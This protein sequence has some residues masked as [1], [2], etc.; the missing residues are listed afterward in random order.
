MGDLVQVDV[1][2]VMYH[3]DDIRS[4]EPVLRSMQLLDS[5]DRLVFFFFNVW[6]VSCCNDILG[7]RGVCSR[8]VNRP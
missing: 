4:V 3:R 5:R 6:Y 1:S 2:F 7:S 8:K